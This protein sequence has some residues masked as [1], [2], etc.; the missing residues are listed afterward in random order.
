MSAVVTEPKLE[1]VAPVKLI[2]PLAVRLVNVPAP[3]D[4]LPIV[5]PSTVPPFISA[6]VTE[7]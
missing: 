2:V 6:V 5:A 1:T 7:P 4:A 3:A